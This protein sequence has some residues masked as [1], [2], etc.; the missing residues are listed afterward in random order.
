MA[1]RKSQ[2]QKELSQAELPLAEFLLYPCY[3]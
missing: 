3:S 2:N 1:G